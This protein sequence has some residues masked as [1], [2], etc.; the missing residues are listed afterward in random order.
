MKAEFFTPFNNL[1][2]TLWLIG[3]GTL[4][5]TLGLLHRQPVLDQWDT[6][7]FLS[8]NTQ[9]RRYSRFFRF[10][11]PLGTTPVCILLVAIIYISSWQAGV[12]A[13]LTY[14]IA[15]TLERITKLRIGRLRPFEVLSAVQI[16]QPNPPHDP[17]H[18]SGDALRVWFLAL[19]FPAAFGLPW[20][21]TLLTCAIA[22]ILSLGRIALGAHYPLDVLGGAGLG[23]LAAGISI[24]SYSFGVI[25]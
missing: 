16:Q 25:N 23:L 6:R 21:A 19:A 12:A 20:P 8:L 9:L 5:F 15:A 4:F 7:T 14:L 11:W 24:T 17:S 2:T 10:I 18:P 22:V 3:I 1:N 13:T